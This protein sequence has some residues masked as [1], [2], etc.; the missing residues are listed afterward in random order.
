M[1][2]LATY[3]WKRY[4]VKQGEQPAMDAGLFVEPV[5]KSVFTNWFAA[6]SNGFSLTELRAVPC[7]V[8]LGD[9]GMGKS[10]TI[11]QEAQALQTAL[12]GQNHEVVYEDLKRLSETQRN[13]LRESGSLLIVTQSPRP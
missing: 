11:R 3:P 8:L 7:L 9:V 6:R 5:E 10:T 1:S 13:R 2:V 4:W 12:A